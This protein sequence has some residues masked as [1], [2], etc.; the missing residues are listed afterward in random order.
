VSVR[1]I[2]NEQGNPSG[3]LADA[4]VIVEADA[5]PLR[6]LT[7]VGFA[8]WERRRSREERDVSRP[9]VLRQRSTPACPA[10]EVLQSSTRSA[11]AAPAVHPRRVQPPRAAP[12]IVRNRQTARPMARPSGAR[13]LP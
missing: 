13:Q 12:L 11:G 2:P 7:L 10:A 5:G 8:V 6:G 9:A 3:A 1:I 4:E